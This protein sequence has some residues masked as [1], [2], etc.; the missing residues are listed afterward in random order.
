MN[1]QSQGKQPGPPHFGHLKYH[2]TPL[3]LC[4]E[5]QQPLMLLCGEFED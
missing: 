3:Q 2:I 5:S 4:S 1:L